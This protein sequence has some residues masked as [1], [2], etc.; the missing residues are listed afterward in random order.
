AAKPTTLNLR[1]NLTVASNEG[2]PTVTY[3]TSAP[4][5]VSSQPAS[6]APP[7]LQSPPSY[8]RPGVLGL[9][10]KFEKQT[11]SGATATSGAP[12]SGGPQSYMQ[13][14]PHSGDSTHSHRFSPPAYTYP[15]PLS[16]RSNYEVPPSPATHYNYPSP[17][18][19]SYTPS[20]LR[21]N[22]AYRSTSPGSSTPGSD[23]RSYLHSDTRS[24][25]NS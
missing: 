5:S 18:Q 12:R 10:S 11:S 3:T 21:S 16:S 4:T 15:S 23:T 1:D 9:V 17:P 13:S 19:H 7:K 2:T 24:S 22:I 20:S 8:R 6:R 14:T 25:T